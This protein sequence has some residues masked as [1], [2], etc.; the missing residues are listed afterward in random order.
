MQKKNI[1]LLCAITLL[2]GMVF[3]ASVATL[4]RQAAGLSVFQITALEAISTALSLALEIPW[5]RLADRMGYRR[6]MIVCNALFFISKIIFW[7]ARSFP[8]FLIERL[9]LAVVI[10]GLSG[11]DTSLLYLSA[12]PEQ[13]QRSLGWYSACG[14]AGLL[15]SAVLYA[16]FLSGQYRLSALWTAGTYAAAAVLTFFLEEV[17]APVREEK[18]ARFLPLLREQL[19]T[20]GM[21]ALVLGSAVFGETVHCVTV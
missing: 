15:L 17:R 11:V 10:S 5:G 20:P 19:R 4:Y 18:R 1:P 7:Q 6:T 12:P 3:Y 16:A 2:Q 9:L 21:P 14:E 8:A 13:A